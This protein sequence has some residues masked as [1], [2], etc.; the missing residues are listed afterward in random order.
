[1]LLEVRIS[2]Q[3]NRLVY[4]FNSGFIGEIRGTG[5]RPVV[6]LDQGLQ[7][8][9]FASMAIIAAVVAA[10]LKWRLLRVPAG[11]AAGTTYLS[12]ILL[13]CKTLG[14]ALYAIVAVPMLLVL[15]P[16]TC[17]RVACVIAWSFAL[18]RFSE[19]TTWFP[20]IVSHPGDDYQFRE[21]HIVR[22]QGGE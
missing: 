19:R 3:L 12:I 4:G 21:E 8:A 7:A 15:K 10:R 18:I 5:Y 6:F 17:V 14:A 22:R 1:M 13:L 2:P 16:R 9:L 20:S 11:A